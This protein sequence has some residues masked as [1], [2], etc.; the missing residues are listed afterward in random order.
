MCKMCS[1]HELIR[2]VETVFY[3]FL[4]H[5]RSRD[6]AAS[7]KDSSLQIYITDYSHLSP[8]IVGICTIVQLRVPVE[9]VKEI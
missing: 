9:N 6:S 3:V 1:F 7:M 2:N 5:G 8:E 4:A